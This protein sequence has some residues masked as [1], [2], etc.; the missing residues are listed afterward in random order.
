MLSDEELLRVAGDY[1]TPLYVFDTRELAARAKRLRSA[2]PPGVGLCYAVKANT[3][4]LAALEPLVDRLE[5]CSPGEHRICRALGVPGE[6]IVLSGVNKDESTV[7]DAVAS[8]APSIVTVE[9]L[10][11]LAL[12]RR[13]A[14][15]RG[16]RAPVLLRL[17]SGNQ[18][19]L[20]R[21]DLERA[22]R[23]AMGDRHLDLRGVQFFSG[24]QKD[25]V[26]R[27]RREVGRLGDLARGLRD[28]CGWE[29]AEIEY[30]PGL[31]VAYFEGDETD[32]DALLDGLAEAVGGLSR[33]AR[34]T[35]ELGR[36]LV[37]SCGTYLTR[38]VD[39]KEVAGQRYAIV[40]GG[41]HQLV[42]Y[43]QSMAM[44]RPPVRLLGAAPPEGP[45]EL[46]W[47][48]CG[49][50]CTTN[51]ILVK[52]LPLAGLGEGSLLAFSR[53]GAYCA[54]EGIALFLSRD[55]PR[56]ALVGAD[57]ALELVREGLR[58]DPLNTPSTRAR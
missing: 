33:T 40:D 3:F 57:G 18:F 36:S 20:D 26:R 19:G 22:A 50:L 28:S 45:E 13:V 54:T 37:A 25:S 8:G 58:T 23:E 21:A 9:S 2:L 31:P 15:S 44:R 12:V 24:T 4:V 14:R 17:S 55:L 41:M 30:G 51:D 35:I 38:V 5:A 49:S 34:V 56:V 42:Y 1:G 53:A 7:E 6:K 16:L 29:V 47:N 39:A 11:Q 48:V 10:A 32:E 52:R 43:G 46:P 27:L